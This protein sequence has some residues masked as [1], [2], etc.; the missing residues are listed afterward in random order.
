MLV[1]MRD[2]IMRGVGTGEDFIREDGNSTIQWR[3][4]L[5]LIEINQMAPTAEVRARQGRP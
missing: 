4:P 5:S 3:E 1:Y 2:E